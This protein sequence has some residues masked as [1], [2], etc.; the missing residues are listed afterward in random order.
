[1]A[2]TITKLTSGTT[3]TDGTSAATAS[4]T[5]SSGK[6]VV[7][8]FAYRDSA[9]TP[10]VSGCGLTWTLIN[11]ITGIYGYWGIA[12]SPSTGAITMTFTGDAFTSCAW[13]VWEIGG[14]NI[15]FPIVQSVT[16]GKSGTNGSLLLNAFKS[17]DNATFAGFAHHSAEASTEGSGFTEIDDVNVA[18][19]AV[20]LITEWK[21]S[22][23][24]TPDASWATSANWVGIGFEV[25]VSAGFFLFM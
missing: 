20:G 14:S 11:G 5:P 2:I 15:G 19:N 16:D 12:S 1:M 18:T 21:A 10:T 8:I 9:V 23:D 13:S 4:I 17:V 24:T 6:V 7:I 3:T 25:D 22:N